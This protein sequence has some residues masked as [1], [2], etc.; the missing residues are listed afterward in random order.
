MAKNKIMYIIYRI[1]AHFFSKFQLDGFLFS[2][3]SKRYK[4]LPVI[5]M[6][7]KMRWESMMKCRMSDPTWRK[8]K[9]RWW[10]DKDG[11][12]AMAFNLHQENEHI[13][14]LLLIVMMTIMMMIIIMIMMMMVIIMM[15][16]MKIIMMMVAINM[17]INFHALL[18]YVQLNLIN[19][20]LHLVLQA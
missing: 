15:M 18:I 6:I 9:W 20:I 8:W 1:I 11:G 19:Y 4:I 14:L 3:S 13:V 7:A 5:V 10:G 17:Y 16:L 12:T 2:L